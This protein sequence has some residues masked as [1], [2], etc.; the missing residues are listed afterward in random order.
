MSIRNQIVRG[1]TFLVFRQGMGTLLSAVSVIF[2][3]RIIGPSNYGLF[4]SALGIENV[5]YNI[6]QLGVGVY[7]I[8]TETE[9]RENYHQAFTLLLLLSLLSLLVAFGLL[10]LLNTWLEME[11]FIE[12]ARVLF[13][14][15]PLRLLSLVPLAYLEKSLA[16]NK[17]ASVEL[18]GQVTYVAVAIPLALANFGA[19]A[20]VLGWISQSVVACLLMYA[21]SGYKPQLMWKVEIVR[22]MLRYSLGYSTSAW[23]WQLRNLVNPLVVGRFAGA[24][25]V[26]LVAL[27]IRLVEVLSFAKQ[28]TYRLSIS[29]LA[30][31]Q[32]DH[33]RLLKAL[34]EG[35]QLQVLLVSPLLLGMAVVGP[36]VLPH[37][38][39]VEWT[40]VMRVFPFIA[41]S[42]TVNALFNLYASALYVLRYNW[43]VTLFHLTHIALFFT[44]ALLLVPRLGITGYGWAELVAF[45]S[46][47][48]LHNRLVV[49]IGQPHVWIALLWGV[50]FGLAYFWNRLGWV[51]IVPLGIVFLLPPSWRILHQHWHTLTKAG[52]WKIRS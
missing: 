52:L 34:E 26:G 29:A 12:I 30:K 41:F 13:L 2:I 49:K 48:V 31:L 17:V 50:A 4:A 3:T 51:A 16:Y 20:P 35:M 10:P 33:P 23:V 47:F 11:R 18:S 21:L 14:G 1:G 40:D 39:G 27:A 25:G 5:L 24:E 28:A 8:R 7:L 9:T 38:L 45:G 19:W 32:N 6:S 44:A 37:L 46:Y 36:Y 15:I 42:Y 22:A 43:E